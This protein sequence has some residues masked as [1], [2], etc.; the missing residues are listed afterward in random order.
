MLLVTSAIF[1]LDYVGVGWEI[2]EGIKF[3]KRSGPAF[4]FTQTTRVEVLDKHKVLNL[5]W[6]EKDL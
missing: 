6:S 2:K 3:Y 5:T 1:S 4:H